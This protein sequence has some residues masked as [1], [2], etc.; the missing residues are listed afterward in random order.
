MFSSLITMLRRLPFIIVTR[1]KFTIKSK[2]QY[3][4][5]NNKKMNDWMS[6]NKQFLDRK[7]QIAFDN[8]YIGKPTGFMIEEIPVGVD[9]DLFE[10]LIKKYIRDSVPFCTK[11][12]I[13]GLCIY[14]ET[15]ENIK[16]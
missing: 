7:I 5:E 2:Q 15:G 11:V 6:D 8:S 1:S 9:H 3:L 10:D 12:D 4:D 14:M 13:E 16:E